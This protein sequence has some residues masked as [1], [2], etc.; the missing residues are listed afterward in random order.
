LDR[1]FL[2]ANVLLS[3]AYRI[4]SG[5][6]VLSELV[7]VE[8]VTSAYALEEARRNLDTKA[9]ATRLE[10]LARAIEVLPEPLVQELPS[11][12][13]LADKDRPILAA[14]L[15]S[16]SS[17]LITGDRQ[18]FGPHFGKRIG[19]VRVMRPGDYLADR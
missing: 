3:A 2:D 15:Q 13:E 7:G 12:V 11:D 4:D 14:A 16:G 10:E 1:L 19:C 5:L 18:H 17:H 6:R 9:R 8:L